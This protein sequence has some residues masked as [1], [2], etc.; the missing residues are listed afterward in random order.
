MHLQALGLTEYEAKAYTALLSLRRASPAVIARQ[1][2]IPR[3]KIYET[4]E[5]LEARGLASKVEQSPMI[6]APLA[7]RE[8]IERSRRGF[9][10]RLDA[11]E[12]SLAQ[13]TN[14]PAP[15]AVYPLIGE[16]AIGALSHNLVENARYTLHLAGDALEALEASAARGVKVFRARLQGLPPIAAQGQQ[17]LL[18]ARDSEAALIAHFSSDRE[19]HG[20]HTHNPI[21]VKLVEGYI[22]L[23]AERD[24]DPTTC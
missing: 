8:Y 14:E 23:A 22:A 21:I 24:G 9:E 19:P 2:Q 5:R 11:L 6:Y 4:L 1:A 20:V 17:V 13:L 18:I 3:P 15:E 7:A 16:A 12:R 10:S